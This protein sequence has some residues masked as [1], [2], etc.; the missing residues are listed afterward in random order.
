MNAVS[1]IGTLTGDPELHDGPSAPPRCTM[2]LAV[3]R[4][5]R[6]GR[7]EPGVVYIGVTTSERWP[8]SADDGSRSAAESAFQVGWTGTCRTREPGS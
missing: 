2:R 5:A 6:D 7:P 8:A 4:R 3:P 1:L